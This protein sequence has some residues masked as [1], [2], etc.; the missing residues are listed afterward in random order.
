MNNSKK[1]PQ[2]ILVIQLRRIGDVLFTLPVIE[3]LRRAFPKARIDFLVEKESAALVRLTAGIHHVLVYDKSESWRWIWRLRQNRYDWVLDFL[4]NG[5]TLPIAFFSGAS[6]K[7]AFKGNLLRS[8]VYNHLVEGD[9]E[10]YLT[11]Q[12]LDIVRSLG[13]SVEGWRWDFSLDQQYHHWAQ[14]FFEQS[15][16]SAD[17]F[18]VGFAP[19]SRRATRRWP[20]RKFSDLAGR[21]I[22]RGAKIIL[23]WGPGEENSA[24]QIAA[25]VPNAGGKI[26]V[27]PPSSLLQMG[28]VFQKCRFVVG[29]DN[30][31]KNLAV[32]LNVPTVLI[33]GPTNPKSFQHPDSA[34]FPFVRRE[35]LECIG[36]EKNECP[37]QHECLDDLS[38]E[39]VLQMIDS[40]PW[41]IR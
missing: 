34:R 12:K 26:F 15:N 6:C 17:D 32:A 27:A 2:K 28:A 7:A 36:C 19:E 11:E 31:A 16:I 37:Y 29:L 35:D 24:R 4:C 20:L 33:A 14:T 10:K 38:V 13:V 3:V 18:V 30:G 8:I 23:F 40:K 25:S 1:N 5:R 21:L 22:S 9:T 39:T 41:G